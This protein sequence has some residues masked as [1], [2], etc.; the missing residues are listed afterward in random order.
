MSASLSALLARASSSSSS[1]S[2]RTVLAVSAAAAAALII[3]L[4]QQ[5][6]G[7]GRRRGSGSRGGNL[8]PLRKRQLEAA[9]ASSAKDTDLSQQEREDIQKAIAEIMTYVEEE[10]LN[11]ATVEKVQARVQ[12]LEEK[13][14]VSEA[15]LEE[16]QVSLQEALRLH[17]QQTVATLMPLRR[18]VAF[19][20]EQLQAL[21]E[22]V[23]VS[24]AAA[25]G[26][27]QVEMEIEM[28]TDNVGAA[29]Q[30]SRQEGHAYLNTV[31]TALAMT[32]AFAMVNGTGSG[33]I[34]GK[35]DGKKS[36]NY[37]ISDWSELS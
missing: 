35:G 9:A 23:Q 22:A 10:R 30:H 25:A 4:L 33:G 14:A 36:P 3:L 31:A 7:G 1:S 17:Q 5:G 28:S 18:E 27:L 11:A 20:Q 13:L 12:W 24:T 32:S 15:A 37:I 29:K 2:R 16:T 34:A 26:S 21:L 8:S 6:T 19:L